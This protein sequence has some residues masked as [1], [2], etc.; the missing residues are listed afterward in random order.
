M[1]TN[2]K[3]LELLK[4]CELAFCSLVALKKIR[5]IV[6]TCKFQFD[7]TESWF[8]LLGANQL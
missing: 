2:V 8:V 6:I 7:L 1:I 3:G 5:L 4:I